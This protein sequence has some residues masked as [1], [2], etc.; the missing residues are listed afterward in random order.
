[1]GLQFYMFWYPQA[2]PTAFQACRMRFSVLFYSEKTTCPFGKCQLVLLCLNI[3]FCYLL[4]KTSNRRGTQIYAEKLSTFV[5]NSHSDPF[6]HRNV[7]RELLFLLNCWGF[8]FHSSFSSPQCI[9]PANLSPTP[10]TC[11]PALHGG[12]GGPHGAGAY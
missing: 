11:P 1:M 10:P 5:L 9:S 2:L 6:G 4:L 8:V 3:K 12:G 7:V